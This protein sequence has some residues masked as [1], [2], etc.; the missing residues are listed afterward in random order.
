MQQTAGFGL[1]LTQSKTNSI[2]GER[3]VHNICSLFHYFLLILVILVIW[4][5][6]GLVRFIWW[7]WFVDFKLN[8]GSFSLA[9]RNKDGSV[10]VDEHA[11]HIKVPTKK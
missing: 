6:V 4:D 11:S 5:L 2:E 3:K 9:P 10:A 7:C 8:T 1:T